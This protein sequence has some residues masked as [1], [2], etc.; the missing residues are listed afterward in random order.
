MKVTLLKKDEV[1]FNLAEE[2]CEKLSHNTFRML[3]GYKE[4]DSPIDSSNPKMVVFKT[5]EEYME[6]A[7]KY[8]LDLTKEVLINAKGNIFCYL[9]ESKRTPTKRNVEDINEQNTSDAPTNTEE[10]KGEQA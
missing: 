10:N 7:W 3:T 2:K 1:E 4:G 8:D 5:K 6:E 9:K